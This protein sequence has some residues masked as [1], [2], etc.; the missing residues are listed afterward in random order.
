MT[1]DDYSIGGAANGI[2][3]QVAPIAVYDDGSGASEV[4]LTWPG[5]PITAVQRV[6]GIIG[7]GENK[8]PWPGLEISLMNASSGSIAKA[9]TDSS[10][11][12]AFEGI[13]S[14][15]YAL[16]LS[17]P[18]PKTGGYLPKFEGN[19]PIEVRADAHNGELPLWGFA[20]SSCGLIAYTREDSMIVFGP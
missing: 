7:A 17:D 8:F 15:Y 4:S 11:H 5:G 1:Q 6:S 3:S 13:P 12:F 2:S 19:I 10:G 16:H 18:R 14:G 9:V 20:M